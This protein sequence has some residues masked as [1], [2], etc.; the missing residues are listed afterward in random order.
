MI[1]N[2]IFDF[3][4]VLYKIDETKTLQAFARSITDPAV[5]KDFDHNSLA[6]NDLFRI[7]EEGKISSPEFRDRIRNDFH[8]DLSNEE[9]DSRWNATLLYLMPDA[10]DNI[11]ELKKTS[12]LALLSNTNEIHY[13]HFEPDCRELFKLFDRC[14]F[15]YRLGVRKPDPSIFRLVLDE[16]KFLPQETIFVDDSPDNIDTARNLGIYTYRVNINNPLSG[17]INSVKEIHNSLK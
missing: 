4:G 2:Y 9:I 5:L 8:L 6:Q 10:F 13:T 7:Y 1:K 12:S 14:F 17:L 11:R 16:M 15:S 3:G